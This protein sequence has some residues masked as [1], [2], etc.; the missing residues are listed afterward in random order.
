[1]AFKVLLGL[2]AAVGVGGAAVYYGIGDGPS[3]LA[4]SCGG[5]VATSPMASPVCDE[6]A[7]DAPTCCAAR[8][9][10][11]MVCCDESGS[12]E[13]VAALTGGVAMGR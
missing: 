3:G 8:G 10:A 1:M 4:G 12:G 2:V 7:A 5:Q 9:K 13:A 6:S 11:Q